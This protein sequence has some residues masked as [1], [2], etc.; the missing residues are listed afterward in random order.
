MQYQ[1][2]KHWKK[3]SRWRTSSL[4]RWHTISL[5]KMRCVQLISISFR[6]WC[7]DRPM[8][9]YKIFCFSYLPTIFPHL[10]WVIS[11][12]QTRNLCIL[13]ITIL[14]TRRQRIQCQFIFISRNCSA[15]WSRQAKLLSPFGQNDWRISLQS[16]GAWAYYVLCEL[17]QGEGCITRGRRTHSRLISSHT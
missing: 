3:G 6:R 2:D 16:H 14:V 12:A 7:S 10:I 15:C 8:I 4:T 9:K 17:C 1:T 11:N 13:L 5:W